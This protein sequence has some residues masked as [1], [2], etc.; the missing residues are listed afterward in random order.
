VTRGLQ[1][2]IGTAQFFTL[3]FGCIIGVGWVVALPAWLAQ[4][5]PG[6]AA[7]AF[8]AGGI[9]MMLVGVCYA[10]LATA[11]PVTGGE[12]AYA[13]ALYGAETSFVTGWFLA[14]SSIATTA[15]EAI[16]LGWIAGAIVPGLEGPALYTIGGEPVRAGGLAIGIAGTA[17][18]T[19][20][21]YRGAG[22]AAR[23]Q[24]ILTWG[25]LATSAWFI[26]AGITAGSTIHLQPLFPD[27]V[28][29]PLWRGVLSVMATAPFWYAGFDVIPQMMGERAQSTSLRAAGAMIL[30]SI[31]MAAVFY[32]LVILASSMTMPWRE[33]LTLPMPTAEG[34]RRA[35]DSELLARVVL[36]A[37]VLGLVTTW[38]SVFMFASRVLF[39]LGRARL[40]SPSMGAA[41][42]RHGSPANAVLFVG[43]ASGAAV[44]LGRGALLPIVNVAGICLAGAALL[45][46]IGV[47]RFRRV[48][49]DVPRP[50]QVPGGSVTAAL[51]AI[52]CLWMVAWALIE[53]ALAGGVPPEWLVLG[54]WTALGAMMWTIARRARSSL[55]EAER[56]RLIVGAVANEHA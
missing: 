8:V 25:L 21:N 23:L 7:L 17:L 4:A 50:Y 2:S 15:F 44:L 35:F 42:P 41:H 5:G 1:R 29:R 54:G 48:A 49:P 16:S 43:I 12:V 52:V 31:A 40:V 13:Y 56:H 34:F 37:A 47:I 9:A 11:F 51:A 26:L 32:V 53:P 19:W 3:S 6:G 20:L 45:I 14:L 27:S 39:T 22:A 36:T 28:D 18:L 33:L 10:E 30:A 46:C 38:N 55:T 24:D